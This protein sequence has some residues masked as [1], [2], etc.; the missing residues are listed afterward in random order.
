MT[1]PLIFILNNT[2][3]EITREMTQEEYSQYLTIIAEDN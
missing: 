2:G 1:R 3:E